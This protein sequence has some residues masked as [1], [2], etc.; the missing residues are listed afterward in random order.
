MEGIFLAAG[1]SPEIALRTR[2][3]RGF[4]NSVGGSRQLVDRALWGDLFF[5]YDF[6]RPASISLRGSR[7]HTREVT[8][9]YQSRNL[10]IPTSAKSRSALWYPVQFVWKGPNER[11]IATSI[12]RVEEGKVVV[13]GGPHRL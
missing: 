7:S 8:I 11:T 12:P 6:K 13:E 4:E 3:W 1:T 2:S 9:T 10:S 5:N